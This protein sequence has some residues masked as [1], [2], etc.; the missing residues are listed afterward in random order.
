MTDINHVCVKCGYE[1]TLVIDMGDVETLTS[2]RQQTREKDAKIQ[3]LVEAIDKALEIIELRAQKS[4]LLD[5][6]AHY[7][8]KAK[9]DVVEKEE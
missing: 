1:T 3:R 2:L 9:S 6:I 4:V 8:R 7:L 5:D